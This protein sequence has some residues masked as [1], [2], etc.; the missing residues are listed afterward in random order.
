MIPVTVA[1]FILVAHFLGD[2]LLQWDAVATQKSYS[3]LALSKH[4]GVYTF[5]L[6]F[7][8]SAFIGPIAIV[9][10]L[11]NGAAHWCTDYITSRVCRSL[12]EQGRRHDFFVFIGI[13]QLCHYVTLFATYA[14]IT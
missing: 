13:D 14:V 9:W 12:W 8:M 7:V 2:F 10:A 6:L 1:I 11:I 4:V 5:V 3:N